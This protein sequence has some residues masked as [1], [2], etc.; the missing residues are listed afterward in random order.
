MIRTENASRVARSDR[1]TQMVG[2]LALALLVVA[3]A[4]TC[5][6]SEATSEVGTPGGSSAVGGGGAALG[7]GGSM[8]GTTGLPSGGSGGLAGA[9]GGDGGST[10]LDAS[11][12]VGGSAGLG[13]AVIGEAGVVHVPDPSN[14]VKIN[15]GQAPWKFNKGDPAGVQNPTFNDS[16]W[17][18]VGVPHTW[19]DVDTFINEQSG[20]GDG[21]MAGGVNWYRKHFTL[22]NK[23]A[24]R[25]VF[26]EIE[27]AHVG[28][29][30][31][32]N[33]TPVKGNSAVNPDATHVIGFV[34]FAVDITAAAHFGGA[35][36]VLAVRVSKSGGFYQDPGFS[37]VFRFGQADG[38]LFRPVWLH[39][40]DKVHVPLNVYSVLNNWGTYVATVSATDASASVRLMTNVQNEGASSQAVTL[41]TKVVDDSNTVVL[42]LENTQ[43][44]DAG[45][46]FTFDQTGT[47]ANP[48]LWY[49]NNSTYGRPN[50]YTV[51]HIVK[52]GGQTVDVF[53]SPLGIRTIT[54]DKDFPIINGHQHHLFGAS[55]RYDYPALG[56]AVPEEQQWRDVKL[57]A[58][59]GGSLWRPGHSSS[60]P[61]WVDA[62]D[63]F[64]VMLIQP[65][66]EGEGAFSAGAITPYRRTLKAE[67]HRDMIIRDRN[68]PSVLAWE[69]SNGGIVTDFAQELKT[70][71]KTWDPVGTRAQADRSPDPANGDILGC[72]LTGCEI[73]VKTRFPNNPAWGSEAWGKQSSRFAYDSELAF[74]GEF[75]QNW[76]KSKQANA[77]G[78]VQWYLA[79][80]PGE[81]GN[82]VEGGPAPRSFGSSMMDFNRIPK[83]LYYIYKAAW[84]PF[85]TKPV[86]ALAHHWNRTGSVRVNAFSN[87]PSVR[88]FINDADQGIKTPNPWTG[89]GTAID[90]NSTQLPFQA[91]WNVTWAS[92]TL[93]AECLN[94]SG[95]VLAKDE[96]VT[97]GAPDHI[98]LTVEPPLVRPN[99]AP[100]AISANGTDA[101]FVLAKIVDSK[102]VW[103]PTAN[104]L[105]TFSVT[106]PGSYRGGTDQ[107]VTA[108][109]PKTYH[110]P[111]DP[112]LQAEGG[113]CK[114]AVR[115]TF[116]PGTVTV[117]ASSTG[118]GSGTATFTTVSPP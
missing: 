22:D 106:G 116:T 94:A 83:L 117:A 109:Q 76:R 12:G 15:L 88:L 30:V 21:S 84:Y 60:S 2:L 31:F 5:S 111:L 74:A 28:A 34:G 99:G 103:C 18:D 8:G 80:T 118:L 64:G 87:C 25:K 113:M 77:F 71:S 69:S 10:A 14:R 62:C 82:F 95:Q 33:G 16:A 79:E 48:K 45:K 98:A 92:G 29:Q 46:T 56:S 55:G 65:S 61:E 53:Q 11:A 58:D 41:T 93:R 72:T 89:T 105:V 3:G 51:D 96:K 115:S 75:I 13:G 85:E 67:I 23:Y 90:Q 36:N 19:N 47:I 42:S 4:A 112:E 39:I 1:M 6:S 101:A 59:I 44:V 63:A 81:V 104:N 50:M 100:F 7:G 54:W 114:V 27:G 70:L 24:D 40:T 20:G 35:D 17:T 66:G 38:G 107:F 78:L 26:V 9:A 108:G 68:H 73:G 97:A 43:T 57:T 49:P 91:F 102:G 52:V 86:V 37:L 32:I 110:S